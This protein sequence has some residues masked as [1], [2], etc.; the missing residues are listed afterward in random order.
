M[1][2][3]VT[4]LLLAIAWLLWQIHQDLIE[5][6]DR[7]RNLKMGVEKVANRLEQLLEQPTSGRKRSSKSED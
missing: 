2:F 3:I 1:L 7:Q 5:S 6:N 4:L